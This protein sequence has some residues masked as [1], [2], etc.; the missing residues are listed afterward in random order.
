MT[1]PV[2]AKL[3]VSSSIAGCELDETS[4]YVFPLVAILNATLIITIFV[5][6]LTTWLPQVFMR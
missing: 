1:A 6:G 3:Y 4:R 2:A 5:P